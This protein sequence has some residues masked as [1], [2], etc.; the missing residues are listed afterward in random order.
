[1]KQLNTD[2]HFTYKSAEKIDIS[3]L[4]QGDILEKTEELSALFDEV[5]PHYTNK[6]YTHFQ[7]LTQSCDLVR[8]GSKNECAS[9]YITLAAVRSLS[10][11]IN[12]IIEKEVENNKR[13]EID[14]LN[15]C[16][17]KFKGRL[18]S[19]L[20]SLFNNNDKNHFFLKSYP[21]AGL[22]N[23]SCTFLHLSVAIRS[24][25]H[26]DLCL[27]AKKIELKNS[28]QSKLGWSVGNLYSRVG[29][30]DFVPGCFDASED[31]KKYI[32]GTLENYVAWVEAGQFA[33]FKKCYADDATLD[34]GKLITAAESK[35]K[36][37]RRA[38]LESFAGLI[39]AT[40][41]LEP[42]EKERL[43]N[44]L[45]SAPARQFLKI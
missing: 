6:E 4:N 26:Y 22:M 2:V 40:I 13:I 42:A 12:R 33:E 30:E 39:G 24:Y 28:F 32:T 14:G 23:D 20:E 7:V 34:G 11:V 31:F 45:D 9:R 21:D 43:R 16:S 10:T 29:T 15:W 17:D 38:K 44:L 35:I 27:K 5:H 18:S 41:N 25:D 19:V 3:T 36:D 1:M 37:K 8:R